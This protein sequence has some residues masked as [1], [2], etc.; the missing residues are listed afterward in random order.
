VNPIVADLIDDVI[1]K[2]GGYSNNPNDSGGETNWGI[3][4]RVA[5]KYGYLGQMR[6]MPRKVAE[7]IYEKRYWHEPGFHDISLI[8]PDVA[9]ELFDTGVN[10]G[11]GKAAEFLQVALNAL[12]AQGK[13]YEDVA[14]DGDI[15]PATFR[16]LTAYRARR[17]SEGERVML[18]AL[19]CL[20]GARYVE[21]SRTRQKDEDFVYGWLKN[22]VVL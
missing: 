9:R 11:T 1:V 22:R 20:Q 15:G 17:G 3:T 5:R 18:T 12:N 7:D 4:F 21:L 10:M 19:N 14:E 2:E 16:A 6:D 13:H 8:Y